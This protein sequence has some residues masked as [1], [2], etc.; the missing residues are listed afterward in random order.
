[1]SVLSNQ[2][3]VRL[4]EGGRGL[5][6]FNEDG[7]ASLRVLGHWIEFEEKLYLP[8]DTKAVLADYKQMYEAV[9]AAFEELDNDDYRIEYIVPPQGTRLRTAEDRTLNLPR[10]ALVAAGID[11]VELPVED[12]TA[13]EHMGLPLIGVEEVEDIEL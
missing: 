13:S 11:V 8:G 5:C 12:V 1:M 3:I 10:E 7:S 6:R 2:R 9:Q 4:P